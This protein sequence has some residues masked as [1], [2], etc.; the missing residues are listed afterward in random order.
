MTQSGAA[1]STRR[2]VRSITG[3]RLGG[4][5]WSRVSAAVPGPL[6]TL[7]L[8]IGLDLLARGGL[9]VVHPFPLLL[10]SVVFSAYRGGLSPGLISAILTTLYG[11]HFLAQPAGT[12]R[13]APSAAYG[14]LATGLIA[15]AMAALVARARSAALL[16][17]AAV[18]RREEIERIDRRLTFLSEASAVLAS[19]LDYEVTLRDLARLMVPSLAD[20]CTVH[21]VSVG[22]V[23][24][25]V[26]GVHRDPARDLGVRVLGEYGD[27]RVPF[28][29]PGTEPRVLQPEDDDLRALA[30]DADEL[31]LYRALNPAS[32][33]QIPL[34]VR[35]S[36]I[37]VITLVNGREY[38]RRFG[39]DAHELGR[40]LGKRASLAVENARLHREAI[41]A[42]RRYRELFQANPQPMWVL[43]VDTLAFLMVN[44]AAIRLYGY[45]RDEFLGMT[46]IDLRPADEL[47]G[48]VAGLERG[49]R[50]PEV[51]LAQHQRKDGSILDVEM[52]SHELELDGRRAR[53]V[54]ATDVSERTRARAALQRSEEQLR[55]TQRMDIVGRLAG[56]AA[57]DFN[58]LLTTIRGFSELLL[59]DLPERS[60]QRRDVEQI[61]RAAERGT[62]LTGQLLAFGRRQALDPRVLPVAGVLR[63]LDGLIR[64]LVGADIRLEL[65]EGRDVGAVRMD[66]GQLE[67]VIVNLVLNARDAMP[68]GGTLRVEASTRQ[69]AGRGRARHLRPG[70]Y[71][72]LC[73][74]DT[75]RALAS[76]AFTDPFEP[77][78][79]ASG[80]TS[81]PG[82]GLSIASGIVRRAG[83][84]VRVS[85]E[86]GDGTTVKVYLPWVEPEVAEPKVG[87]AEHLRGNE[88]VLVAED[89]DG[90]RDLLRKILMEHGH[91]VLEA[92]HGRDAL[93]LVERYELPIH[94]LVTDVVMPEMGGPELARRLG[95]RRPE[96]RILYVS[97]YTCD[98]VARRGVPE[99]DAV[100]VQ[101]PF[102]AESLMRQVRQVLEGRTVE[103]AAGSSAT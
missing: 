79:R 11:V 32:V 35:N 51:A 84:A 66:P 36:L 50:R 103:A 17:R 77:D 10:L 5:D 3:H 54:L 95:E 41:E 96:V 55:Q 1:E 60:A 56:S 65:R 74:S 76:E 81:R 39:A 27:R 90:V 37:G 64:R 75:G 89:E 22:G 48:L 100:V 29:N 23:R 52:V 57:H 99:P 34:R 49:S 24:H 98:E 38:G 47:P 80:A 83:G 12:L 101:K 94:L 13:Y 8:L 25:F 28:G 33:L 78:Q 68:A 73:V 45:T 14:L 85:S 43:D 31:A 62:V 70:R 93:M 53:L 26:A 15:I 92:R 21:L 102:T 7:A 59:R 9:P 18:L 20:W 71:V 69:I 42:D 19:S 30:T 40:E 91:T 72:V 87:A 44:D 46:I 86:P 88:T 16:G 2:G 61:R 67:Q 63:S 97:G 4:L 82:L 58:N 6:L